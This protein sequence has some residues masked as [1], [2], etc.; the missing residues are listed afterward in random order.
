VTGKI[1]TDDDREKLHHHFARNEWILYDE[2]W[3]KEGL[4]RLSKIGYED[5]IN[6][7]VSKIYARNLSL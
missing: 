2:Q 5:D 4:E 6:T 7:I 3:V 1:A